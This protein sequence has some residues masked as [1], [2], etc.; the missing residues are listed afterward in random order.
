MEPP[1][2]HSNPVNSFQR[3]HDVSR[4]GRPPMFD[5]HGHFDKPLYLRV[6]Y[7]YIAIPIQYIQG[8]D[9]QFTGDGQVN[10]RRRTDSLQRTDKQ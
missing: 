7:S 4:L 3:N 6:N 9:R 1:A 8:T 2:H 5:K 10:Y